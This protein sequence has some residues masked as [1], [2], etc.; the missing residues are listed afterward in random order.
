MRATSP[1]ARS[2]WTPRAWCVSRTATE[3][4][5]ATRRSTP[6]SRSRGGRRPTW[7]PIERVRATVY[8]SG[9]HCPMCAAAHAWVGLGRIVYAASSAQ[10]TQWLQRLGYPAVAG[11]RAAHHHHCARSRRRRTGAR[12]DGDDESAVRESVPAVTDERSRESALAQLRSG[13]GRARH[14]VADLSARLRR[15]SPGRPASH[16]R[17]APAPPGRR[18]ARL[19]RRTRRLRAGARTG[20]RVTHPRLRHHRPL[21]H[22]PPAR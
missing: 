5:T 10:L 13:L 22:R 2:W 16:R 9:E 8:T 21:P 3:P 17:R 7:L 4:R 19:R 11:G 1:S 6:S 15:R 18:L 20:V 14:L 12:T